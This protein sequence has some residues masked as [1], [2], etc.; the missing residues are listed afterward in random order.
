MSDKSLARAAMWFAG[1]NTYQPLNICR[2]G[3][4]F[5]LERFQYPTSKTGILVGEAT[6][7]I[8]FYVFVGT[9][10]GQIVNGI[11]ML[12]GTDKEWTK[13]ANPFLS[14]LSSVF[15]M[16][17][18]S[19]I[20]YVYLYCEGAEG[21]RSIYTWFAMAGLA[22][23]FDI[24]VTM[25]TTPKHAV[26]WGMGENMANAFVSVLH[27]FIRRFTHIKWFG[28]PDE[29]QNFHLMLWHITTVLI[30]SLVTAVLWFTHLTLNASNGSSD[31]G[32]GGTSGSIGQC[33]QRGWS[34]SLMAI[35]G[36]TFG[37]L[38]YP[39][40]SPYLVVHESSQ[41]SMSLMLLIISSIGPTI[42]WILSLE[43]LHNETNYDRQWEKHANLY[44]CVWLLLIPAMTIYFIFMRCLHYPGSFY[45]RHIRFKSPAIY[46]GCT[47]HFCIYTMLGIGM[48]AAYPNL[49]GTKYDSSKKTLN[50][51]D[52]DKGNTL[53]SIVSSLVVILMVLSTIVLQAYAT[54]YTSYV[55]ALQ[56][57]YGWPTSGISSSRACAWWMGTAVRDG[58]FN[59]IRI[60]KIDIIKVIS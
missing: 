29:K 24:V 33:L 7:I 8:N 25:K 20:L 31:S 36:T 27:W 13:K 53:F 54:A 26:D 35:L 17:I 1:F 42:S 3:T 46:M 11:I 38:L 58:F 16:L 47:Y 19:H 22:Y 40:V 55:K 14:I 48:G 50:E 5:I 49:A 28:I 4:S 18:N 45:E 59:F 56:S 21:I 60:Y 10:I 34:P 37:F 30:I 52:K 2:G 44:H 9:I 6:A 41:Y 15:I 51:T 39:C 43:S 57:G 23:S 32:K 12:I